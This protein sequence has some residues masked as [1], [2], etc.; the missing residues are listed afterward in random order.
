MINALAEELARSLESRVMCYS[1]FSR[2]G[3]SRPRSRAASRWASR[4]G[5]WAAEWARMPV[6][7]R[8]RELRLRS[9]REASVVSAVVPG[10]GGRRRGGEARADGGEGPEGLVVQPL[11]FMF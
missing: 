10:R 4:F 7:R 8:E 2:R 11:T 6:K 5:Q 9:R 3:G 1:W